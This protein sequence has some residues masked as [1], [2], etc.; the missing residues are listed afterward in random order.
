MKFFCLP[1]LVAGSMFFAVPL[2]HAQTATGEMGVTA[3]V[4]LTCI[5][6]ATT[7]AFGD[8]STSEV[9]NGNAVVTLVCNG[10]STGVDAFLVDMGENPEPPT[11]QRQMA[12][13]DN[14]V[15][16][17]LHVVEND[18]TDIA[19]DGEVTLEHET[20]TNTYTATIFGDIQPSTEYQMGSYSDT[21]ILT[22]VYAP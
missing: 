5:L 6:S 14:R 21:V 13:G 17:T 16:Y 15:P 1:A 12:D 22:A 19:T 3:E 7:L 4:T 10:V 18:G 8:V 2:S 9:S 11:T 20:G